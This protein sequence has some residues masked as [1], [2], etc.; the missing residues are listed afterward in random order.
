[1]SANTLLQTIEANRAGEIVSM[2][3]I[4]SAHRDVLRAAMLMPEFEGRS[5]LIEATSNQVN[6]DGGYTGMTPL[7]FVTYVNGLADETGF[8]FENIIF[9][10]DH[11]GPQ[12]WK[13]QPAEV[14]LDR[15]KVMVSAYVAA[16]FTKIHLD[17]S[18]GCEGEPPHLDD[19]TVAKRAALLA[20]YCEA[21]APD[22]A[23]LG[24][25]VGTEVP[26]PGGAR[27]DH[28]GV[29]PT[30]PSAA[31]ATM[32]AHLSTFSEEAASRINGL[33]V[34]PGVEFGAEEIDHL[35][36]E[37][38]TGLREVL[39]G[40]PSLTLEAH[41]TDYQEISAYPQL[42]AM[43]F[44]IH[45]VGPALTFAYRKAVYALD[46]LRAVVCDEEAKVADV[47]E[48]EMLANPK[49]WQGHYEGEGA[50]LR[51]LRHY[52]YSDRIRYYWPKSAP[53]AAVTTLVEDERLQEIS[54]PVLTQFFDAETLSR[55]K[56]LSSELRLTDRL[57]LA[58]IQTAIS[59]Y[60]L[61]EVGAP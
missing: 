39:D 48:A 33:V 14:A 58:T 38:K 44:A 46:Q 17:C 60:V 6:Q 52:S 36:K 23:K 24:Y 27:N 32:K 49:Y 19:E 30:K 29:V 12:A 26:V 4:C 40:F 50:A 25:I 41:S 13:D 59:P 47:M 57:I 51:L 7:D 16:G 20:E 54:E 8:T 37:D 31:I 35:P 34:Q 18:E 9:G 15:A 61:N 55:A 5:L 43:G 3:S 45:K 21:A 53:Q 10:G 56:A 28:Q 22:V 11:L 42:A 1:M 2:P